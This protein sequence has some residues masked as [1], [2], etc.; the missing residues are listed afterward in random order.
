MKRHTLQLNQREAPLQTH[1]SADPTFLLLTPAKF[2]KQSRKQQ[3]STEHTDMN[4]QSHC[5]GYGEDLN[6]SIFKYY[7]TH[8]KQAHV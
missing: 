6:E 1:S 8:T 3:T 5:C 7:S 4:V 2:T